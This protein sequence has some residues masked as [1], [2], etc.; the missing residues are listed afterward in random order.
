MTVVNIE[1]DL[2]VVDSDDLKEELEARGQ[3][4]DLGDFE[5]GDLRDELASRSGYAACDDD[6]FFRNAREAMKLGRF[7]EALASLRRHVENRYGVVL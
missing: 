2:A 7:D 6:E 5:E 4:P 3:M 1:I